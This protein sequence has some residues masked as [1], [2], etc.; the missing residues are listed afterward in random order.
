LLSIN[1]FTADGT[2]I[3]NGN[4][5]LRGDYPD[6][7]VLVDPIQAPINPNGVGS[8]RGFYQEAVRGL[9]TGGE[10][11]RIESG[12]SDQADGDDSDEPPI[13]LPRRRKESSTWIGTEEK[14]QAFRERNA[15]PP[16]LSK[17]GAV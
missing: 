15:R 7:T 3:V 8:L 1:C 2:F 9:Q 16:K 5:F 6:L 14:D 4:R 17:E 13:T 11:P 10:G 12:S